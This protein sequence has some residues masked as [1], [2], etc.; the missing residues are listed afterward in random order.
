MVVD[1]ITQFFARL[2]VRDSL[3]R[4]VDAISGLR[5]SPETR[6]SPTHSEAPEAAELYLVVTLQGFHDL[7]EDRIDD[8]LCVLLAQDCD[9]DDFFDQIGLGHAWSSPRVTDRAPSN[10]C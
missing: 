3:R 6:T 8:V 5:I 2:E 9:P 7:P 4:H 10:A 1:Q